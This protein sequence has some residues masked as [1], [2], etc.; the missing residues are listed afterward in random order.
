MVK[1][2]ERGN[3]EAFNILKAST[4]KIIWYDG[5]MEINPNKVMNNQVRNIGINTAMSF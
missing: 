1:P 4:K 5:E 3:G 2:A